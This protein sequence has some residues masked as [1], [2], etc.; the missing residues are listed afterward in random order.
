MSEGSTNFPWRQCQQKA[1]FHRVIPY[2][3]ALWALIESP[4]VD[5]ATAGSCG[6]S[7]PARKATGSKRTRVCGGKM[8][9]LAGQPS[10]IFLSEEEQKSVE[11]WFA[12][13]FLIPP[14]IS[15]LSGLR[16]FCITQ[17]MENQART[18]PV[19]QHQ[20]GKK[21]RVTSIN[22]SPMKQALGFQPVP[23]P[24]CSKLG[25]GQSPSSST[26][27]RTE[28]KENKLFCG[29]ILACTLFTCLTD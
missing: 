19:S 13:S 15:V 11:Q 10:A 3:R 5:V 25:N 26:S 23:D 27:L 16:Y 8:R 7:S 24:C 9:L 21:T 20:P 18:H 6:W 14:A 1:F 29:F 28:E 17:I 12:R 2:V 22:W 4:A